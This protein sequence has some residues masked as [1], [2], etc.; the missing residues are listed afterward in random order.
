M[1]LTELSPRWLSP[2][3]FTFLCPH[4]C[5]VLLTCKRVTMG[6]K[7]QCLLWRE[8]LDWDSEYDEIE[9][10]SVTVILCKAEC[11][12]TMSSSDFETMTVTPSLD[13]SGSGHWHG[14]LTAGEIVG[15]EQL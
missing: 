13:A 6:H 8:I 3:V 4:C 9:W 7:A 12:W 1:R 2:D 15:G 14:F 11:A 5:K 10:G